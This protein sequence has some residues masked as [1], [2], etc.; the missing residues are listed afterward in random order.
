MHNVA[1]KATTHGGI[2]VYIIIIIIIATNLRDLIAY[3]TILG[4]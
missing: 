2:N 1:S 4:L 3:T